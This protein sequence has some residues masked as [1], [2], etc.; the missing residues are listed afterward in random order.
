MLKG[1]VALALL[2]SLVAATNFNITSTADFDAGTKSIS[3]GNREVITQTNTL[4]D[5]IVPAGELQLENGYSDLFDVP[6]SDG[7]SWKWW[8]HDAVTA[9]TKVL[10]I[11]TTTPGK[12]HGEIAGAL[13]GSSLDFFGH[14]GLSG[15]F[16]VQVDFSSISLPDKDVGGVMLLLSTS[17]SEISNY[18]EIGR[19][20]QSGLGGQIY[21]GSTDSDANYDYTGS[22]DTSGK[23]RVTRTH[24][25]TDWTF[26][27]YYWSNGWVQLHQHTFD[28][29]SDSWADD[30][31]YPVLEFYSSSN[32]PDVSGDFDNF[33]A[34]TG[35]LAT[36]RYRTSGNWESA[37]QPFD[38]GELLNTT[39]G[40]SGADG[41]NYVS[42]VEWLVN[43]SVK[44]SYTSNLTGELGA[45]NLRNDSSLVSY[46]KLENNTKDEAGGLDGTVD[47]NGTFAS[48]RF[49]LGFLGDG[50]GDKIS[51]ADN[52][53]LDMHTSDWTMNMWVNFRNTTGIQSLFEKGGTSNTAAGYWMFWD[54]DHKKAYL[55]VSNGTERSIYATGALDVNAGEWHMMT[56]V[57]SR[58]SGMRVYL[59]GV[60][61]LDQDGAIYP[62]ED[63]DSGRDLFL[64]G[65]YTSDFLNGTMDDVAIF[66]RALS[67]G[68]VMELYDQHEKTITAPTTGSFGDVNQSFSV[69][70]Y[71]NGSG[72]KTPA[73][74][75]IS[76]NYDV[77]LPPTVPSLI[78]PADGA[79]IN[80]T[81]PLLDWSDSSDG[82]GDTITYNLELWQEAKGLSLTSTADFDAGTKSIS[83]GNR[84]V[85]TQTNTLRDSIVPAGELQLENGYSDLFDVPS[86][87]GN[88]WKWWKHD[89]VTATTKV[90][91]IDTTTP[92]KA[93]GEIAGALFGSSLDFFGHGGL[94]GDFDV[95]V[96]FSSISLPD[97]DVGGVMLLLSTSDSEIS[98][99][100]EIG[101]MYQSGLGGQIYYGSTDSDANYDYT[102]SSDTSGKYRVTRT[103]S[104]TD[105]TFTTYYWSNGWVQL[106]QHTFDSNS[107][108]WADDDCYPVLEFYSSSNHPDVSGD[109]D[110]F[111]ANTGTL[112]TNRYRTSG[113]WESA[114]QPFDFGELLN[115][116]IGYSGADGGN[117]VSKVEWL[118]NGSV[119]ASYTSN[120]T[121]ELGADNLRNDSSLVSYWKLENNTKDEAGGLDGTV[122]GNGTFASGRF[123]L[124]FLGDGDGD[125]ISVADNSKLDMHT[126]DWTMNMWV[127]FRNTTGIQSLFEK[128]GTSNTA[129]GY[130][131]FWD[132]DHKKAYLGVSNGTERSIYA[133][134]ALDV[135]AGEWHMMTGVVSRNSGMRVY[136][137][138]VKVLDQ[139]GAIYPGEDID[140]GRDLFLGGYYTSDFLN[141][142]MDDV[143]I[144]KRALSS[145][146][147]MELYDQHEKTITAPTT[148]SFGDVNQSFSVRV[149]LNGSG[150][151]TP[152]IKSI[153]G[154]YRTRLSKT[155]LSNS[156]YRLSPSEE[157]DYDVLYSWEVR[158]YDGYNY[159]SWAG[160]WSFI[161]VTQAPYITEQTIIPANPTTNDDL[162]CSWVIS[163]VNP[164]DVL[165]ANVSW[166]RNGVH[167][168]TW[169]VDGI[170]CT[171]GGV[172]YT[173]AAPGSNDTSFGDSWIC[174][175]T[176][177]DQTGLSDQENATA[178]MLKPL[179]VWYTDGTY[180]DFDFSPED[181]GSG[182]GTVQATLNGSCGSVVDP[183]YN[184]YYSFTT[185]SSKVIDRI[186][187]TKTNYQVTA[188]TLET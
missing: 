78:S 181:W 76:G 133:T 63:I 7:N 42:K 146:E 177:Y 147:V 137:D 154:A 102:G 176:A 167:N 186:T 152:A 18:T 153:Y 53:K 120:L 174:A 49:G 82:E 171:N 100:T 88:S 35:T 105:W 159:S 169:D 59:D 12:A 10:D 144:F 134:G 64:G 172:C 156:E 71:L 2:L 32:H 121:G 126:S 57:V 93:H 54:G 13:F 38:F 129:A 141:G 46:W 92:G 136:L 187:F 22:S 45:D 116:T 43:G 36:N 15:D 164:N 89:A 109:F 119:K 52:S 68:E 150:G 80:D 56:G 48:G 69:R 60:K 112:A 127:N 90:L 11:D 124:G 99:Y 62:G 183:A 16:D 3:G 1:A 31:C 180:D 114:E 103:H 67:S 142:T 163:D 14:G 155:G 21:Y 91:D 79:R 27:T 185:N 108:S 19:M 179:V 139:D 5:S 39:I 85:I 104:G 110:N 157:L 50:D 40:Y 75:E 117:Y 51:V 25:G 131:M 70:V 115:T 145:G 138:G 148:G 130:W 170:V 28:S 123:G 135:N 61:V 188:V 4:R 162:N 184:Y 26:T 143:A 81:T 151:K 83:G 72:G 122:D 149:Y 95:Q 111:V 33:V 101:R 160:P 55:G 30:D 8:K 161:V 37:E 23:Y 106:H 77:N 97:K 178:N 6:S 140:S 168:A 125:K 41:G 9:T 132:G 94:S 58:N 20:Y 17:D 66:K 84:E 98:N 96:D 73:I 34:N 118:V 24:S 173:T 107:D 113:N 175:I 182:S 87:D 44:A 166:Y 165:K 47:G 158:A 65:Y 74:G 86:S 128:G 29:N